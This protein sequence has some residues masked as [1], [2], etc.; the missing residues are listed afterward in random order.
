MTNDDGT[1]LAHTMNA[2]HNYRNNNN[3]DHRNHRQ[4]HSHRYRP[5]NEQQKFEEEERGRTTTTITTTTNVSSNLPIA[6]HRREILYL[7]ERHQVLVIIGAT[8]CGKTTQL[9]QYLRSAKWTIPGKKVVCVTQPR[10]ASAQTVAMRVCEE[11]SSSSSS[12]V[13]A[14]AHL[15][16]TVGVSVRF[17]TMKSEETEILFCTD[18]SLLRELLEDPLLQK[19]SVVM[20]DE[21]HERSLNTDVLLGLLKKVMRRRKELRVIVSSATIDAE[22]FR[23]FFRAEEE[24]EDDDDE[25]KEKKKAAGGCDSSSSIT[26]GEPAILSVEGR[27]QHPVRTFYSEE[28]VANY[29]KASAECAMNVVR[30]DLRNNPGDILIFLTGEKEVEECSEILEEHLRSQRLDREVL[31]CP[32]YAGLDNAKQAR[33]FRTPPKNTR[34]IIIATNIAETSVTIEGVSYVIDCGFVKIKAF[35][36]ERNSET[37]QVV[38]ASSSSAKQRAGRAGRV[39][40]G[41]CFRLYPEKY[42]ASLDKT[43]VPEI[44]R[45]DVS[46]TILQLKALGIDNIAHFDWFEAPPVKHVVI[47]LELLHALGA[48]D[49]DAKL[50]SVVGVKLAEL[51]LEPKLGKALLAGC[52]YGCANEMLTICSYFSIENSCFLSAAAARGAG[53]LRNLDEAKANFAAREGDGITSLNIQRGYA[54]NDRNRRGFCEENYLNFRAMQRVQSVRAQLKK[55]LLQRL[56]VV[57]GNKNNADDKEKTL[58]SI[59]RSICAGFFSNAATLAPYGGGGSEDG[60]AKYLTIRNKRTVYLHQSSILYGASGSKL[61]PNVVVYQTAE[62]N[63]ENKEYIRNVSSVGD[64]GWFKD[65]AGHFY[66]FE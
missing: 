17:E 37:L 22:A 30:L 20:V 25:A 3:N 45:A 40:P 28:P 59:L 58:E 56:D 60:A 23:E 52:D 55:L 11:I 21:A 53:G 18:G 61:L 6:K 15:G 4:H 27:R 2:R 35:D 51:P 34:K 32:L 24:E 16:G 66:S 57:F 33:A 7:L 54:W 44:I 26:Y 14:A 39:R 65:D 50:T 41:T 38:R 31:V 36:C 10:R 9:C 19:Y 64:L 43:S 63:N 1:A 12:L 47:A 48:I 29:I 13:T 49:D 62:V 5:S 42:F 8:G 46:G